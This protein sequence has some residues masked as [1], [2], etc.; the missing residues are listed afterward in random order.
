MLGRV[1]DLQLVS[2]AP[3]LGRIEGLIEAGRAVGI[4]LIHDQRHRVGVAI[5]PVQQLLDEVRPVGAAAVIGDGDL[6]PP[7]RGS[8]ATNRVA[9]PLRTYSQSH[10]ST[11][12]GLAG[13]GSRTSPINC[14]VASSRHTTG[15][16]GS[17]GR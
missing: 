5:T 10:R 15:C 7:A 17:A 14:L 16:W 4:E 3:G 13:R 9:V 1:V 12:P 6:A 11:S 8:T 2:Q